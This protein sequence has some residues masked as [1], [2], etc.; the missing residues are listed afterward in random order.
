MNPKGQGIPSRHALYFPEKGGRKFGL[1]I[2]EESFRWDLDDVVEFI[3]P[4]E[5]SPVCHKIAVDYLSFLIENGEASTKEKHEFCAKH[6]YSENTLR[7]H[8]M[9]KLYR[10]GLLHRTRELP[11]NTRRT[12][13]SKRKSIE[14]E[15]L[16]FAAFLRKMAAEWEALVVTGRTRRRREIRQEKEKEKE[17]DRQERLEWDRYLKEKG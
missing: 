9:P 8:V 16:S 13:K 2:W 15:S 7:K 11:K 5:Y 12:L 17:L 3:F 1:K 10:F 6:N 4:T 14:H